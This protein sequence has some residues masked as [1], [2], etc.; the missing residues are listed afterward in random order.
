MSNSRTELML[1]S[2]KLCSDWQE[3]A[4]VFGRTVSFCSRE[5]NESHIQVE[6]RSDLFLQI[7]QS[8]R[9]GCI[10]S[11]IFVNNDLNFVV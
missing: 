8:E 9:S 4:E 6:I 7:C 2:L 5:Q 3:K 11:N 1:R 10:T